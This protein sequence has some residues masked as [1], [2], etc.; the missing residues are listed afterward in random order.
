MNEHSSAATGSGLPANEST[1]RD[2][3]VGGYICV[4][5][6][7][8]GYLLQCA[9]CIRCESTQLRT[10]R[11]QLRTGSAKLTTASAGR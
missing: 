5:N 8:S 4:K 7:Y 2:A 9:N 6:A 10:A 1:R 3:P 11:T